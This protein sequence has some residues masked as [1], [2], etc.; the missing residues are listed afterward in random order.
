MPFRWL[1]DWSR[2]DLAFEASGGDLDEVFRSAWAATLSAMLDDDR[3]PSGLGE[4]ELVLRAL[5]W[6]ELMLA[7][8]ERI[9]FVKDAEGLLLQPLELELTQSADDVGLRARARCVPVEAVLDLLRTDVKAVT[10]HRFALLKVAGGWSATVVL[11][12]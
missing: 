6:E 9:V 5:S 1:E 2:A 8:L 11:D 3:L 12:V 4:R 10:L 7:L